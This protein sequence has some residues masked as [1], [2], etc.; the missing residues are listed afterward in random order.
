MGNVPCI[1]FEYR[2]KRFW[3]KDM[4]N[5]EI[6]KRLEELVDEKYREFHKR[7]CNG[8]EAILGVKMP[9]VEALAK[10]IVQSDW[11]E[12][13][14]NAC[15]DSYEEIQLQGMVIG[16]AKDITLEEYLTYL[17]EFVPKIDNWAICDITCSRLKKTKKWKAQ[18]WDFLNAYFYSEEEFKIRFALVM[19]LD[20]YLTDDYLEKVLARIEGVT[21]E[22][23]YVKMAAAWLLQ[24]AFVK[25]REATLAF[26]Q[27]TKIDDFTYNKALQKMRE[28]LRVSTEDKEMLLAMK[29]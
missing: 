22:G 16:L 19:Y 7:L 11:R 21:H 1:F 25:H 2:V 12:Y 17:A 10:E 9:M 13:L 15:D 4:T 6:R 8:N 27:K 3:K 20:Y 24:V 14:N 26:L 23:Y 28:S 18:M 29:R 5:Q